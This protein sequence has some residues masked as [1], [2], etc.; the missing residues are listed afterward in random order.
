MI[1]CKLTISIV[2][3]EIRQSKAQLWFTR[4]SSSTDLFLPGD[5]ESSTQSVSR[6]T[7]CLVGGKLGDSGQLGKEIHT[8][9]KLMTG[10]KTV[11]TA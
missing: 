2:S 7:H 9:T 4:I 11:Y 6:V 1:F 8:R 5:P 3:D 10:N